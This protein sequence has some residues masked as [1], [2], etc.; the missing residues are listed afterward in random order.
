M[1][2]SS[3]KQIFAYTPATPPSGYVG[4]VQLFNSGHGGFRLV[5]RQHRG[6]GQSAECPLPQDQAF[7][8]ARAILAAAPELEPT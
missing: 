1:S 7:A 4:Y 5:V 3:G 8:L 2:P 6:D